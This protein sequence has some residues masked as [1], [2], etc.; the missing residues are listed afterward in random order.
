MQ[1]YTHDLVTEE[2]SLGNLIEN[3]LQKIQEEKDRTANLTETD[4]DFEADL[5]NY[6][7][8]HQLSTEDFV[9]FKEMNEAL[10][11]EDEYYFDNLGDE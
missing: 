4:A 11:Q 6:E 9:K 5:F 1:N 8:Q 7:N 3:A 2:L 10:K